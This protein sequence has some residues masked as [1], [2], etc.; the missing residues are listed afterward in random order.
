MLYPEAYVRAMPGVGAPLIV[1]EFVEGLDV[2]KVKGYFF[3]SQERVQYVVLSE[4]S[5]TDDVDVRPCVRALAQRFGF[6]PITDSKRQC[7]MVRG[8]QVMLQ[9]LD[10][11]DE[12]GVT[13]GFYLRVNR[14]GVHQP[15]FRIFEGRPTSQTREPRLSSMREHPEMTAT[16]RPDRFV[17]CPSCGKAFSLT[18]S[19]R[20]DGSRHVTCGQRIRL[21][22]GH[23]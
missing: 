22:S 9:L 18:D 6:G 8:V 13:S 12:D 4:S 23:D 17:V 20:W 16:V 3:F 21:D 7:W 14:P 1:P 19:A 2:I 15:D 10:S 5:D 11:V